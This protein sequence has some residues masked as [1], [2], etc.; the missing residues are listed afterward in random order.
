MKKEHILEGN[1]LIAKFMAD[2]QAELEHDLKKAGT[3]ESMHYDSDWNWLM[4]VVEKIEQ[5]TEF[6]LVMYPDMC[7]W[8]SYGDKPDGLDEDFCGSRIECVYEAVVE[9]IKWNNSK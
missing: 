7:Y 8:N 4:P 3:L 1:R 6:G 5:E 2:N 9:F